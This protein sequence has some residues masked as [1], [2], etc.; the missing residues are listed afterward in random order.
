MKLFQKILVPLDGSEHSLKA[1]DVAIQVAKKFEGKITLMHVYS[2]AAV[3]SI[4]PEPGIAGGGIPVLRPQDIS[5]FIEA[6]R[7]IGNRILSDGKQK[8]KT[9]GVEADTLL[10]E[11][12]TVQEIVRVAKEGNFE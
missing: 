10:K 12:H 4:V 5:I 6:A 8:V 3:T 11:G 7:K 9:E 1:L 2:V